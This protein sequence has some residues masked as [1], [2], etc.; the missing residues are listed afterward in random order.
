MHHR[1]RVLLV[2]V[3]FSTD[4]W[5]LT[6]QSVS[7]TPGA[8][9][10]FVAGMVIEGQVDPLKLSQMYTSTSIVWA[11]KEISL[12]QLRNTIRYLSKVGAGGGGGWPW[13]QCFFTYKLK[14]KNWIHTLKQR[15]KRRLFSFIYFVS[16]DEAITAETCHNIFFAIASTVW[17]FGQNWLDLRD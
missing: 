11:I 13:D 16:S 5:P 10:V 1:L 6:D 3:M 9:W 12:I 15:S 2:F 17:T 4:H 8:W 7:R 14:K